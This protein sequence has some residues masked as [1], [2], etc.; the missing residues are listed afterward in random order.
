MRMPKMPRVIGLA[1]LLAGLAVQVGATQP[2]SLVLGTE[3]EPRSPKV[4]GKFYPGDQ[5]ELHDWM[6]IPT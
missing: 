4:A 5:V 6:L 1:I 3:E 2:N